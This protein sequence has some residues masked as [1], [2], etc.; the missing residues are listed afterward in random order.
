MLLTY[1][2]SRNEVVHDVKLELVRYNEE[3]NAIITF[4]SNG[5]CALKLKI[6]KSTER[7]SAFTSILIILSFQSFLNSEVA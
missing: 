2:L 5:I 7:T 6:K 1:Q 4:N 3:N